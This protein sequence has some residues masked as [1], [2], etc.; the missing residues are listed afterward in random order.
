MNRRKLLRHLMQHN[1]ALFAHG[2]EHDK[3]RRLDA[4]L[5]TMVPRHTEIKPGTVNGICRDLGIP[6]PPEK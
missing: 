6:V 5:G 2:G 4:P 3:W 1:C